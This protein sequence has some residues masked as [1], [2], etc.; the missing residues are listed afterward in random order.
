MHAHGKFEQQNG[1]LES[2][3]IIINYYIFIIIIHFRYC[4]SDYREREDRIVE[5][6][7]SEP[8]YA[9]S[10]FSSLLVCIKKFIQPQRNL[11]Q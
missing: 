10:N 6:I 8:A 2:C 11:L 5:S 9:A 1:V 7:L 4:K 3:I